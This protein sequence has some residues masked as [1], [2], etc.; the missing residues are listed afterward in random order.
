MA[1]THIHKNLADKRKEIQAYIGSLERDLEQARR[2]LSAIVATER[3]FQSKGPKVTAYMELAALFPRHE[4]PKLCMAAM[5][6]TSPIST[7]DIA[8]YVIKEKK[9]EDTR[10]VRVCKRDDCRQ[11]IDK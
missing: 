7:K 6:A 11:E 8:A 4:L 1:E 10:K 5:A 2:D 9:D 3:V